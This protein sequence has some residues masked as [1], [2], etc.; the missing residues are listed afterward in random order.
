MMD[1]DRVFMRETLAIL[2]NQSLFLAIE[3]M[4]PVIFL[5]ILDHT[6]YD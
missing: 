3:K 6:F 4:T 1:F 2:T 5:F